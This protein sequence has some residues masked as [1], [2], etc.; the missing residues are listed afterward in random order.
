MNC[1]LI[2]DISNMKNTNHHHRK[3]TFK[4][5][6]LMILLT[7]FISCQEDELAES[8]NG[9]YFESSSG[10]NTLNVP[11]DDAGANEVI[12]VRS[13]KLVDQPVSASISVSEQRLKEYN[14]KTG[15][16][17]TLLPSDYYSLADNQLTIESG[18]AFSNNIDLS[19]ESLDGLPVENRY[20]IPIEISSVD[21]SLPII[22]SSRTLFIFLERVFITSVPYLVDG[23]KLDAEYNE[24][25]NNL[26]A[27]TFEWRFKVD[28]YPGN[29]QTLIYSYPSEVYTRFGDV[30]IDVDQLQVKLP[31]GAQFSPKNPLPA[32][33]WLHSALVFDGS[34][35][36]WYIDGQ[37]VMS[38]SYSGTFNFESIGFGGNT[39]SKMVNEIR[40]WTDV[41]TV[42]EIQNNFYAVAPD[43]ENLAGYWKCNEGSGNTIKDRTSNQND[44][45]ASNMFGNSDITWIENV[46]MPAD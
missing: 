8:P 30:V 42:T 5:T 25:F 23:I 12:F 3:R 43:S 22:E 6:F 39:G 9:I 17:F 35:I 44:M 40:F 32:N 46:R 41:R 14:E 18:D 15:S 34:L 37:S 36:T 38:A 11:V 27:W 28:N 31:G 7:M 29:N 16:D 21:G 1:C 10:N 24:P 33:K 13:A 20:V 26:S 19:I 45:V 4:I 2:M